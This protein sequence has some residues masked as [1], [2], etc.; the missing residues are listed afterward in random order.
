M[1]FPWQSSWRR[2]G[3]E[4]C[5]STRLPPPCTIVLTYWPTALVTQPPRHA[6]LRASID[7]SYELLGTRDQAFWRH[8]AVF[9]G[10]FTLGAAASIYPTATA[11]QLASL[12]DRNSWWSFPKAS[13]NNATEGLTE[14]TS[15]IRSRSPCRSRGGG[16]GTVSTSRSLRSFR[17]DRG[18]HADPSPPKDLDQH[19]RRRARKPPGRIALGTAI[20]KTVSA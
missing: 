1:A 12:V 5:L 11:P 13:A 16:R 3:P 17:R 9:A 8:L 15:C 18:S 19:S 7:W 4:A 6:S 10:G 20:N 2:L 14:H